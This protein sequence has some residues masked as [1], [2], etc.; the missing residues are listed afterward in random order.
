MTNRVTLSPC[1]GKYTYV[2][3]DKGQR[4]LLYNQEWRDL[5]GD[6]FALAMAQKIEEL[7]E[8]LRDFVSA[9]RIDVQMDGPKFMG[10]NVSQLRRAWDKHRKLISG[11]EYIVPPVEPAMKD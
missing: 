11:N 2:R 7:E 6:K 3:D 5:T 1:D 10:C 4:V 9:V 8:A